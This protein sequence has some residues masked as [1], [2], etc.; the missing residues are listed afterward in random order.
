MI[1]SSL[2]LNMIGANTL[3][4]DPWLPPEPALARLDE[5]SSGAGGGALSYGLYMQTPC[6]IVAYGNSSVSTEWLIN[7][8]ASERQNRTSLI[9]AF[10]VI[11]DWLLPRNSSYVTLG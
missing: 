5:A 10:A 1:P 8:Q 4:L 9:E 3:S 11:I 6:V 7:E 2:T